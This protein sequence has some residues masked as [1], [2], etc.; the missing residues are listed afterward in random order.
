MG[1]KWKNCKNNYV[2][3]GKVLEI[4]SSDWSTEILK[5]HS[6]DSPSVPYWHWETF[7]EWALDVFPGRSS[8]SGV[9]HGLCIQSQL[10][11][12]FSIILFGVF[13][14]GIWHC[15]LWGP[16]N[17]FSLLPGPKML[18]HKDH[19]KSPVVTISFSLGW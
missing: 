12:S 10:G 13:W 14:W 18:G 2:G 19:F 1:E 8:K 3:K 7:S 17:F 11:P 16:S 5:F 9:L 15:L 6:E 4:H